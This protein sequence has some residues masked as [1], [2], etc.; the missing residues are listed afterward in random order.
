MLLMNESNLLSKYGFN[1]VRLQWM[2]NA[3]EPTYNTFNI[4]YFNE[5]NK[6]VN[7]LGKNNIY[8]ILDFH[9]DELGDKFC[10]EHGLPNWLM[11]NITI[12]NS[13]LNF[14]WPFNGNCSSRNWEENLLTF[15]LASG[16]Q[17]LYDNTFNFLDLFIDFWI[18]S[19]QLWNNNTFILGYEIINEPFIGNFYKNPLLFSSKI[20]GKI[21]LMPFYNKISNAVRKYDNDKL[22]FY[23][24]ITWGMIFDKGFLDNGFNQIPGGS[25]FNYKSVYSYHYYCSSFIINSQNKPFLRKNIC[26]KLIANTI[27]HNTINFVNNV[28]GSSF[29]TEFGACDFNNLDECNYIVNQANKYF[30]SWTDYT[31]AQTTNLNFNQKWINTFSKPYAQKISGIPINI[32]FNNNT[33]DFCFFN[34]ISI[35]QPTVIF[36]N[37]LSNYSNISINNNLT[38]NITN[39]KLFIYNNPILLNNN[40]IS[41]L[42]IY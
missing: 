2:W 16:F 31:Y 33:F 18:K 15:E 19:L 38:F 7:N 17:Y 8:T 41:C 25:K 36:F 10:S 6:I 3:F 21:N 20:A 14:P 37:N 30:Q 1:I 42:T 34:N 23:E 35:Y 12:N 9:Q 26:D 11:N 29:L 24:P 28:G 4:T 40:N 13:K 39:N 27:F 5:I 32:S 22:L